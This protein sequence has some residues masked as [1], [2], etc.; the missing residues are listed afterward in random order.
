MDIQR[1]LDDDQDRIPKVRAITTFMMG[2]NRCLKEV[3]FHEY[4]DPYV[5]FVTK[6]Q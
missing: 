3:T 5:T 1:D 4:S 2:V 6:H